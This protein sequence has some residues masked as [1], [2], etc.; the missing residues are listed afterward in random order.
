MISNR[1][2]RRHAAF[3]LVELV[4]VIVILGILA[5]IILP[6]FIGRTEDARLAGAQTQIE[7]FKNALVLYNADTG[8]FPAGLDALVANPGG[9]KWK[10]PYLSNANKVPMDPWDHPYVYKH[11]GDGGHD[12]DIISAGPDGLPGTPDDITSSK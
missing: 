12:F 6:R 5:V 9:G 1:R 10:G 7:T 4:I 2:L 8:E 11:P 3:T